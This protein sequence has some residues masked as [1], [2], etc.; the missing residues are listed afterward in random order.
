MPMMQAVAI[1]D[2]GGPERLQLETFDRPEP[3][4]NQV[5]VRVCAASVNPVDY[6][7]RSGKYPAV[8][9]EQL[10]RILGRD[11][12][13]VVD[14]VGEGV[15]KLHP[16]E[17]VFAMLDRDH[18]GYAEYVA[19]D[20]ELCTQKP[21]SL[22]HVEAAAVPLA[23]LTAWQGLFDHG[24]LKP[25]QRVLIHGGAG[26]VGHFAVQLAKAKGAEVITT[27]SG[28]DVQFARDLGAD[29]VIDY[30][31]QAFDEAVHDVDLVYDLVAGETQQR[32][33]SVLKPGGRMVS[34][35]AQ[36]SEEEARR[37]NARG[38]VYMAKPDA[39]ELSAIARLID[40]GE[41]RSIVAARFPLS[42]VANAQRTL[43]NEHVRGKLV[44]QI[45]QA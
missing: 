8:K 23:A 18:G 26:G 17:A 38:I 12:S 40:Q 29:V 13:G 39:A 33:W 11:I 42:E 44:L 15:I 2:F 25:K 19:I 27:V 21:V 34:T 37:H 24:E 30:R 6:K 3:G 7:T 22:D 45:A 35:L 4:P 5:L 28:A 1:H 31:A 14:R 20:A 9:R 32:S 43:E 41:V 36:P 16:G 10:P